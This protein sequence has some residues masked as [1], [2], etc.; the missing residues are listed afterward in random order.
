M[1]LKHSSVFKSEVASVLLLVIFVPTVVSAQSTPYPY[2]PRTQSEM[3]AYLYGRIA[4]L[5]E[6]QAMLEDGAQRGLS[7]APFSFATIDTHRALEI[8]D[9]SAVLRGEVVLYGEATARAWF[10]YGQD[11]YFLDQKT[12]RVVVRDAYGRAVRQTVR[13]LQEDDRYYFRLVAEDQNGLVIY[14]PIYSFHT[15][16]SDE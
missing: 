12:N 4:M 13:N 6:F 8:T 3:I 9:K 15:D 1:K 2:Q 7:V 11:E 10:E 5:L 16:E 14:G